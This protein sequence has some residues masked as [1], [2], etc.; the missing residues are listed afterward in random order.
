MYTTKKFNIKNV[1]IAVLIVIGIIGL[2]YPLYIQYIMTWENGFV[3]M[4]IDAVGLLSLLPYA[5]WPFS[6]Y[7]GMKN[8]F[9][10]KKALNLNAIVVILLVAYTTFSLIRKYFPETT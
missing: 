6:I 10:S 7:E 8:G 1:H 2:V 3:H 5:I 9:E 4:E